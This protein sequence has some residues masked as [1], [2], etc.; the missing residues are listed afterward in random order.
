MGKSQKHD[1]T[2]AG[3]VGYSFEFPS[4]FLGDFEEVPDIGDVDFPTHDR[5]AGL[6][7]AVIAWHSF[8]YVGDSLSNSFTT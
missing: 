6:G 2:I 4:V 1:A 8:W 3:F 5:L 7:C